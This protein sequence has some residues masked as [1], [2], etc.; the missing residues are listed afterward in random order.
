MSKVKQVTQY[1]TMG[2]VLMAG[3]FVISLFT[4]LLEK[5]NDQNYQVVQ[6]LKGDMAIRSNAG[7][8]V[9][10]F[11]TI[12]TYPKSVQAFFSADVR[13]GGDEDDSIR[14]TFNDGG[15]AVVSTIVRFRMPTTEANR[16]LVHQEFGADMTSVEASVRAHL[17]NCVKATATMMTAS[18]NQTSRKAEFA[19]VIGDQLQ[20]G[21]YRFKRIEVPVLDINGQVKMTEDGKQVTQYA[22]AIVQG[23]NGTDPIIDA[24]SPLKQYGIEVTQF[25]V[26]S[27]EYDKATRDQF[28]KKKDASLKA[29]LAKI[30]V[31]QAKQETLQVQEEG[32]RLVASKQAEM[33]VKVAEAEGLASMKVAQAEQE[34]LEAKFVKEKAEIDAMKLVEVAK[35]ELVASEKQAE[36]QKL[37]ADAREYQLQKG[38]AI[39]ER[40]RVLVEISAK[41]DALVAKELSNIKVP[42]IVMGGGGEGGSSTMTDSLL[43]MKLM[44]A[45]GILEAKEAKPAK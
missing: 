12:K 11:A 20:N 23:A 4:G 18:E 15:I 40:D 16:L 1:V 29:E 44:E 25:S 21:L 7:W 26:T 3:V 22:T 30:Q 6:S 37:L 2:V 34:K 41:R 19:K 35:L 28:A 38:G 39:S 14:A 43:N 45:L 8:Y 33:N 31:E 9:K 42:H 32:K 13:E 24:V 5:N 36:A 10:S 17:V 27:V